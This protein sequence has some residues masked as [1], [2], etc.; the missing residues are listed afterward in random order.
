[1][2]HQNKKQVGVE[3]SQHSGRLAAKNG[4]T[5]GVLRVN[6]G[7]GS[8]PQL[9]C[10]KCTVVTGGSSGVVRASTMWV[11][12]ADETLRRGATGVDDAR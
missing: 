5:R 12:N 1:M 3:I 10:E 4:P 9:E 11:E 6:R 7:L 2:K 8:S